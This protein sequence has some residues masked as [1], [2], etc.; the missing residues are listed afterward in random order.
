[1]NTFKLLF[2]AAIASMLFSCNNND[3]TEPA[4]EEA[5]APADTTTSMQMTAPPPAA[6]FTAFD[7]MEISHSVKDYEKWRPAFDTDSTERNAS[8][9]EKLVVARNMDKP[10]YIYM[11]FKVSDIQKAKDFGAAP[12]LK[13]V[14]DKAGVNSKPVI[15]FLHVIRFNPEAKE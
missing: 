10:N 8:G 15:S 11:A 7:I 9:L 3:T 6:A 1:M 4:K 5:A 12:R 13:D 14:M 2:T